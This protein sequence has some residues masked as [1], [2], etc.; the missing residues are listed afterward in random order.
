MV[1]CSGDGAEVIV[2]SDGVNSSVRTNARSCSVMVV[3]KGL[4]CSKMVNAVGNVLYFR[5][6]RRV[7]K[8]FL[9]VKVRNV[10]GV[11]VKGIFGISLLD[12]L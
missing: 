10:L 7:N 11:S 3:V 12:I 8:R 4:N 9:Q 5:D 1:D 6:S 2:V